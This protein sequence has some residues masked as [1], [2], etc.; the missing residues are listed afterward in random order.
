MLNDQHR[1]VDQITKGF[2]EEETVQSGLVPTIYAK[3]MKTKKK[4]II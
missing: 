2:A 3:K 1:K 4:T